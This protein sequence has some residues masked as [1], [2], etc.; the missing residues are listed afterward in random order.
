MG[1]VN[2]DGTLTFGE[3][4]TL[5]RKGNPNMTDDE[6]YTLF[7]HCDVDGSG[8]IEFSEFVDFIHSPAGIW[9]DQRGQHTQ[10]GNAKPHPDKVDR[11]KIDCPT[12]GYHCCP[13]WLN[14]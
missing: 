4:S 7:S 11:K 3:M 9:T 13:Q 12:C 2:G 14:D 10:N 8:C 5:L 6:L 1:D